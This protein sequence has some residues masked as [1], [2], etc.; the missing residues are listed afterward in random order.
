MDTKNPD[1]DKVTQMIIDLLKTGRPFKTREIQLEIQKIKVRC[2][3]TT[4]VLLNKLRKKGL[5]HGERNK[6][7]GGW[8][9]WID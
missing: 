2:P 5:I 7:K 4:I 1:N 8:V 9:W 6:E 3:D